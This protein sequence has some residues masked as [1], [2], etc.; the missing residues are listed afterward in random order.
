MHPIAI[1]RSMILIFPIAIRS[2]K[3]RREEYWNWNCFFYHCL[4]LSKLVIVD[5]GV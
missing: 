3:L 2:I 1:N 4:Y 5:G